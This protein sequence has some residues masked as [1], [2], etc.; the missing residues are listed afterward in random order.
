MYSQ[1]KEETY[2]V[3]YFGSKKGNFLD[4]GGYNPFKF[5]NTRKLYEMGWFGTYIEPSP[6]CFKNFVQEYENKPKITLIN[7][8]VVTDNSKTISF[9][10]SNGDAVSTSNLDHKDKWERS[11]A[12]FTL[13]EVEAMSTMEVEELSKAKFDF[14]S[15]DVESNNINIFNALSDTFLLSL[16]MLCIEH[17]NHFQTIINRMKGFNIIHQNA[18]N[19][20]LAK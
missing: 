8:A 12:K 17:D 19:L 11:G 16:D 1:N 18:E 7:K 20:I 3:N 6:V 13:I 14:L 2:I 15:L 10:D 4:I 5:S 9:W